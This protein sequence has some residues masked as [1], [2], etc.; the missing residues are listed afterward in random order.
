LAG[1]IAHQSY[2]RSGLPAPVYRVACFGDT[3]EANLLDPATVS[4]FDRHDVAVD[5]QLLAGA[6]QMPDSMDDV[7][8][9]GSYILIFPL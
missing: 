2:V 8:A 1:G 6:W 3:L 5:A 7:T 9:N 4:L